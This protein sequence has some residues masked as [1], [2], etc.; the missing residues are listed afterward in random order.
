ME[1][2]QIDSKEEF[3]AC[4]KLTKNHIV[5]S[6]LQMNVKLAAQ[7]LSHTV[8]LSLYA[9]VQKIESNAI[10]TARFITKMDVLFDT[11][12]FKTLKH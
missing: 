3:S 1:L 5:V 8:A 11:V 10:D 12:N 7:V 6:G 2:Y 9:A 4:R